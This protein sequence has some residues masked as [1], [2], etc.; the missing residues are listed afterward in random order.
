MRYKTVADFGAYTIVEPTEPVKKIKTINICRK[1]KNVSRQTQKQ[2][3]DKRRK[4]LEKEI[5][6]S[7]YMTTAIS[8]L[9]MVGMVAWWVAVGY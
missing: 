6:F 4:K 3:T 2:T 8:V 1:P 7:S 5:N 9:S